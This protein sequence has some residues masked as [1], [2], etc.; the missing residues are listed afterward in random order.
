MTLTSTARPAG[1]VSI[2]ASIIESDD[3]DSHSSAD[4]LRIH[5]G[6]LTGRAD[7]VV[8]MDETP[9]HDELCRREQE[10]LWRAI[11]SDEDLAGPHSAAIDSLR[12][13]LAADESIRTGQTVAL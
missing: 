6:G 5:H 8:P 4:A 7:E 3:I 13:V 12:I 1:S 2:V 9:S 11:D 10:W